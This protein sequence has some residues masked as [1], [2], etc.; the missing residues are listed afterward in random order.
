M[1]LILLY[2]NLRRGKKFE[3]RQRMMEDLAET[4]AALRVERESRRKAQLAQKH[5]E[6]REFQL[7]ERMEKEISREVEIRLRR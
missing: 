4:K 6:D 3:K 7:R 5:A 1:T 2:K